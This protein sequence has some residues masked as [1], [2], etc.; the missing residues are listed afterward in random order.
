[1]NIQ[2]N[3]GVNRVKVKSYNK[4]CFY[5]LLVC[6]KT[7]GMEDGTISDGQITA[8][9]NEAE[10]EASRGRLNFEVAPGKP[11]SWSARV[12]DLNQWLQ[13][14]LGTRH[15]N[16]SGVAT[17]GGTNY[18]EK[19]RWVTKYKLKFSDDGVNFQYYKREGQA[20][21]EVRKQTPPSTPCNTLRGEFVPFNA[22]ISVILGIRKNTFNS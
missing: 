13:V 12:K 6:H 17:Q 4:R 9:S 5:H 1:M 22:L 14:D 10:H 20:T 8:S 11:G 21:D 16:I 3:L 15:R 18:R 2:I 7:I 19:P